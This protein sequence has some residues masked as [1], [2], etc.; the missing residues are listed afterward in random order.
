MTP[1]QIALVQTSFA[2]VVPIADTAATLFYD[3]LFALDPTLRR[4]FP[5]DLTEQRHKLMTIL[6]QSQGGW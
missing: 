6:V 1:E 3:R 2:H 5:S 4:L